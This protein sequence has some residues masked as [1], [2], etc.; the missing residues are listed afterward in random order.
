MTTQK[1]TQQFKPL[2][3]RIPFPGFSQYVSG[4]FAFE[5]RLYDAVQEECRQNETV[6]ELNDD[7]IDFIYDNFEVSGYEDEIAARY[8]ELYLEAVGD[9]IRDSDAI[10][11]IEFYCCRTKFRP[12]GEWE[13]ICTVPKENIE[14]LKSRGVIG[15]MWPE[16]NSGCSY[17]FI[18]DPEDVFS[19]ET[20]YG[21]RLYEAMDEEILSQVLTLIPQAI[22]EQK[23][24]EER[25]RI[26]D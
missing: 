13:M 17:E 8:F 25:R 23:A 15:E 12:A 24:D 26:D 2:R 10:D 1:P 18:L 16:S 4:S 14:V 20:D 6:V 9:E 21:Q 7:G 3:V 5:N 22:A 11:G 19:C